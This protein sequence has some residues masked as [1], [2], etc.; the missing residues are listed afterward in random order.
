MIWMLQSFLGM[1]VDATVGQLVQTFGGTRR[2]DSGSGWWNASGGGSGRPAGSAP[3]AGGPARPALAAPRQPPS[4]GAAEVDR[5]LGGD[6]VKL[7]QYTIVSIR[8]CEERILPGGQGE[9]LV[10]GEM[11]AA[12]F[13]AWVVALY[14][15]QPGHTIR[16]AD[17]QYLRVWYQVLARWPRRCEPC[18]DDKL[19]ALRGIRDAL[20]GL[21]RVPPAAPPVARPAPEPEPEP[22]AP[23]APAPAPEP[24]APEPEPPAPEPP[25]PEPPKPPP[26]GG[27]ERRVLRALEQGEPAATSLLAARSGL[28]PAQVRKALAALRAAGRVERFGEGIETRY[29]LV[30]R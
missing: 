3:P 29:R 19:D 7:V 11:T 6:A 9:I 17:K 26:L 13:T 21:A 28:S 10:T 12:A 22:V 27:H 23:P 5:D 16:H 2:S 30:R 14:L 1:F 25:T 4:S 8:R 15:Q 20:D 24:Q 18:E